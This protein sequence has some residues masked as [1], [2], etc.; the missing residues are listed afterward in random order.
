MELSEAGNRTKA[1]EHF[2]EALRLNP[3]L[4]SARRG[5]VETLASYNPIYRPILKFALAMSRLSPRA[6]W[7]V[8]LGG[9]LGYQ[10]LYQATTAVPALGPFLMPLM[11]IYLLLVLA[12]WIGRPRP[13]LRS[14]CILLGGLRFRTMKGRHRIG[15]AASHS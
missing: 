13:T 12:T 9:W 6:Q 2:R 8:V 7:M 15:S 3:E 10:I 11:F 1:T 5:I 4:E 14:V